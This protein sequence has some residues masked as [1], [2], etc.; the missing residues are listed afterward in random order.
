ML[1]MLLLVY[2]GRPV[3]M[4]LRWLLLVLLPLLSVLLDVLMQQLSQQGFAGP[5]LHKQGDKSKTGGM[6]STVGYM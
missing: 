1:V 4:L 3:Y 6:Q 2:P 5:H